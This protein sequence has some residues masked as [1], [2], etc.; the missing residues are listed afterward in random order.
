M[1]RISHWRVFVIQICLS[2]LLISLIYLGLP[3]LVSQ[4]VLAQSNLNLNSDIIS[5][6]ARISRLEQQV[7]NLRSSNFNR[8]SRPSKTKQPTATPPIPNVGNPPVVDG[9][10]IGNTDP[11]Y[12][13]LATLLIELK[14]DVRNIDQRLTQIE[15]QSTANP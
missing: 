8:P 7:N 4:P 5:L 3:T 13:R 15:Q 12:K 14:E 11:L 10:A 2:C 6:K 9:Q 1:N